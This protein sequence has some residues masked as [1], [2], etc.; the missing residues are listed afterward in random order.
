MSNDDFKSGIDDVVKQSTDHRESAQEAADRIRRER[1]QGERH[2]HL[3]GFT[4]KLEVFGT[5]PG[6][7][8]AILNDEGNR[9]QEALAHG[10]AFVEKAE[11]DSVNVNVVSYDNDPGSGRVR[12]TVGT[13]KM[14]D[15]LYGYLMKIPDAIH[16]DDMLAR[17]EVNARVDRSVRA[18]KVH[19]AKDTA[20]Q[21]TV[22]VPQQVGISYEPGKPKT[23]V[24]RRE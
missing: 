14:G 15:P 8:M 5:L 16:A 17:E 19:D 1:Q 24:S 11:I 7:T 2:R 3:G 12:F 4:K 18:G 20:E 6:W 10:Y 22:Y 23:Y 21:A 13:T 9:I